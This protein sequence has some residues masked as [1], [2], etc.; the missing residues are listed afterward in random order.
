MFMILEHPGYVGG[1]HKDKFH[2]LYTNY[3]RDLYI[4]P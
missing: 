4:T 2:I 3:K 1:A